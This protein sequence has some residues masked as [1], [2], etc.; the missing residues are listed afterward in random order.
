[1]LNIVSVGLGIIIFIYSIVL[2]R[3]TYNISWAKSFYLWWLILVI[4]IFLFLVSYVSFEYFLITRTEFFDLKMIVSQVFLWGSVFVLI[5]ARLFYMTTERTNWVFKQS[6][7][8][9]EE[10]RISDEKYRS[11]VDSTEDS[12]YMVDR[13]FNYL[14]MNPKHMARLGLVDYRG[15]CYG[16]CHWKRE[17][18]RFIHKV[19]R[20]FE[21]GKREQHEHEFRGKWFIRT[22]SPVKDPGTGAVTAVTVV[23]I[24]VTDRKK[25][26]EVRIENMRLVCA[27]RT[28]SDFLANMSHELRTPLNAVIGFSQLL[29][30]EKSGEL[31]EK[32]ERYV[33]NVLSGSKFLL[34]LINDI[35]DLSKI[36]AGKIELVVENIH[37]EVV[38]NETLRLIKEMAASHNVILKKELDPALEVIEADRLRFKQVM[39]NLLNNAIKFSKPEGGIVTIE[40]KMDGDMA[41]FSVSDNGIGIKEENIEKL[42]NEFEQLDTGITKKYGGSGLGLAISKKL[43]ELHEGRIMVESKYGEGTTFTFSLPIKAKKAI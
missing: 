41:T 34:D 26:E 43:V 3:R 36:E 13:N 16:D 8:V 17:T 39:F 32:Q 18:D 24:D 11:L 40:T 5:C 31:N 29:K 25:A 1:M 33:D 20:I 9:Q 30:D 28:K 22:L 12:I 35:L 23:S 2:F 10:L 6:R 38:I 19:S 27:T 15:K 42:F 21:T 14:F 37:I 7:N 4:F